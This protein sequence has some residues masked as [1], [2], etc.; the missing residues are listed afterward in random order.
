MTAL[1]LAGAL[2]L[3]WL[4][5][6]VLRHPPVPEAGAGSAPAPLWRELCRGASVSGL[7]P[8]VFLLFLALLPQFIDPAARW[9]VWL[10]I[11]AMGLLHVLCCCLVYL[12]V[13]FG[14]HAVLRTRPQAARGVGRLSGVV[15]IGF[16]STLL[17]NQWLHG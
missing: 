3:L 14:S 16:G 15:M 2:Y 9:P 12:A 8:K 10:Q 5:I 4:R 13:G 7:N 1:T 6:G 11:S 17:L